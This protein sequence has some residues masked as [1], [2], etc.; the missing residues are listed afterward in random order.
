MRVLSRGLLHTGI[1]NAARNIPDAVQNTGTHAISG[2][3]DS[4]RHFSP[5]NLW[6]CHVKGAP[7]LRSSVL[8]QGAPDLKSTGFTIA[9]DWLLVVR[10]FWLLNCT[11]RPQTCICYASLIG[12]WDTRMRTCEG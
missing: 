6:P 1:L 11:L 12:F 8:H 10:R 5:P 3:G 9:P 7:D 2:L 4:I